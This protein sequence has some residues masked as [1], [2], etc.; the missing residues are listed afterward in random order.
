MNNKK[1]AIIYPYRNYY[2]G[3]GIISVVNFILSACAKSRIY[4]AEIIT[5]A[6]N[7]NDLYSIRLLSPKSWF[8]GICV[9]QYQWNNM[10][11]QRIGVLF[12]EL[13]F[14]RYQPNRKLTQ[15]IEQY[16]LVQVVSGS[17]A[18]ANLARNIGKPVCLQ[19]A[20]LVRLERKTTLQKAKFLRKIY[21]YFMLPIVS[22]IEKQ[23][24]SKMDHIFVDT[25]YTRQAILPYVDASK[26][27]IDTIGVDIQVFRP[28]TENQRSDD[29][30]LSVGRFD[31]LRKNVEILFK[32]YALLRD[33]M[34]DAP[35]LV[36]AGKTLPDR[37]AWN[38]ARDLGIEKHIEIKE[39][40][41]IDELV[42]LYQN[43]VVYI[44]SSDE[45]GLGIV[46]LEAMACATPVIS[47]KC[48]G[49]NS[50]VSTDV[51]FLTPI[52]DARVMAERMKW[53]IQNPE[54][55][56]E[57]GQAGRKMV[58]LRFSNE[59][60]GK[61]FLDVYDRLLNINSSQ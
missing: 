43:A 23:A 9:S 13:E 39:D 30:I 37:S 24:L 35:K 41:S 54:K 3:C 45:E 26:I 53:M 2:G 7:Y 29:Y 59:V 16:D 4:Q 34:A 14:Q 61:K 17:P 22:K 15:L 12:S 1:I 46:L 58:E 33:D 10:N 20:T 28:L 60:V 6:N 27:T 36:L 57:M 8:Q 50:V 5:I 32:A 48:G 51:G 40:V 25:E 11:A 38:L 49:P 21:G 18:L 44:L 52:G 55:R 56:R 42:S 31:D 47:T 19:M